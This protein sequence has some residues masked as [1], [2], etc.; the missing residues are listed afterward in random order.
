MSFTFKFQAC[1]L[2]QEMID[3]SLDG[4]LLTPIQ[5]ICKYPLQLAEL[6]KFTDVDHPDHVP[7]ANALAAMKEVAELVNERKRRMECLERI[8][9]WQSTI[10]GWEVS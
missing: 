6:L 7:V 2:L 4:F 9:E 10:E 1:R 3:I 8:A 5:R